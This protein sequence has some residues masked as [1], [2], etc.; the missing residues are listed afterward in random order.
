MLDCAAMR[1]SER[2]GCMK[3]LNEDEPVDAGASSRAAKFASAVK[4]GESFT[5]TGTR[6]ALA[7]A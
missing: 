6:T 1:S 7:T 2:S 4:N 3:R 5:A